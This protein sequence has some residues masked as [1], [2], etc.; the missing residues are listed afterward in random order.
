RARHG[1]PLAVAPP[2]QPPRCGFHHRAA[3]GARVVRQHAPMHGRPA[4]PTTYLLHGRHL[5]PH[6]TTRP[7]TSDASRPRRRTGES[8]SGPWA[9]SV[10]SLGVIHPLRDYAYGYTRAFKSSKVGASPVESQAGR[11]VVR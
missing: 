3:R 2:L 11:V 8:A 6:G 7:C 5:R 1:A 9:A 10:A 4:V